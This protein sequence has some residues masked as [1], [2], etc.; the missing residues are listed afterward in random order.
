MFDLDTLYKKYLFYRFKKLLVVL[1]LVCISVGVLYLFFS[2]QEDTK[3]SAPIQKEKVKN[4]KSRKKS[5]KEQEQVR[6]KEAK[7]YKIFTLSVKEK[8]RAYIEKMKQKYLKFGLQCQIEDQ[9]N[10]LN[11]VCGE[12][13][14]YK[15]YQK[16]KTLLKKNH[17]KYYLVIKKEIPITDKQEAQEL[18]VQTPKRAKKVESLA[19]KDS[20][21]KK[22]THKI[23]LANIMHSDVDV[24]LLQKKFLEHKSYEI[25]IRIA[26]EYY[27]QQRYEKS[28]LWAKEANH[29]NR[30]KEQ[31]WI[32]YARSLYVLGEKE[33]AIKILKLY[34]HFASSKK[35]ERILQ[36]WQSNDK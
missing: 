15:E 27:S 13:N 4:L 21:Q 30:K 31:S 7:H 36:R 16:I 14:S 2:F 22:E 35:V 34:K 23:K 10:Y 29:L 12:T 18:N 19:N 11:L 24:E 9:N 20:V 17:I 5:Q 33:K 1:I 3:N 32:L 6:S 26:K 28:L 8:S 25:A